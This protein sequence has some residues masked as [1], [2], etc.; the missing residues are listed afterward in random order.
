MIAGDSATVTVLNCRTRADWV[1][2]GTVADD[3][4][5]IADGQVAGVGDEVVTRQNNRRVTTGKNMGQERGS[6]GRHRY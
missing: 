6:L 3:G 5:Q 2:E 1:R 4:L